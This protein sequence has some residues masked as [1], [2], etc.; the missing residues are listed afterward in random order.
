MSVGYY[1]DWRTSALIVTAL[2]IIILVSQLNCWDDTG[3]GSVL[4]SLAFS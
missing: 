4:R 2:L 3:I 1:S